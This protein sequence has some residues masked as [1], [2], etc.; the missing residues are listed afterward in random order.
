MSL[1]LRLEPGRK[2][3][4]ARKAAPLFT[5]LLLASINAVLAT[6]FKVRFTGTEYVF[7]AV[8]GLLALSA[9]YGMVRK[10]RR[11]AEAAYYAALWVSITAILGPL[12]YISA[13][14][15]FPLYDEELLAFDWMLGFDWL[16]YYGF[17][18]QHALVNLVFLVAYHSLLPQIVFS[19]IFLSNNCEGDRNEEFFWAA[20]ISLVI[21]VIASGIFPAAGTFYHFNIHL[22]QAVH[23][24]DFFELRNASA[25]EFELGEMKGIVT[26]PSFHTSAALLLIYVYRRTRLFPFAFMLNIMM[27]LSTPVFGGHYLTDMLGGGIVA[28]LA[29]FL[30]NRIKLYLGE[31]DAIE[32]T[33]KV[34]ASAF[35]RKEG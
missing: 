21:T 14:L 2:L 1:A 16:S 3:V 13:A 33:R 31:I 10:D 35:K 25:S 5:L 22:D 19:L 8:S 29:V 4:N 6:I 18:A 9:T 11:I 23:L 28:L 32:K 27:L 26:F 12:T 24:H 20:L 15:K 30:G 17:F 34:P 7:L